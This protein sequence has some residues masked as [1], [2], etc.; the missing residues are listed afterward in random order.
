MQIIQQR[1]PT[2]I[3]GRDKGNKQ[4]IIIITTLFWFV[5]TLKIKMEYFLVALVFAH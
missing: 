1:F 2:K 3:I 4:I 5:L